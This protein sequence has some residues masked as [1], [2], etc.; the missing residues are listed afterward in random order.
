MISETVK[1]TRR[2]TG[3]SEEDEEME[4]WLKGGDEM[5]GRNGGKER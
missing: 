2:G 5:K 4:G 3:E 1:K